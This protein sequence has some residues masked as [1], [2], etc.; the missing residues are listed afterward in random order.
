MPGHV[1][2]TC[3]TA[4]CDS[5]HVQVASLGYAQHALPTHSPPV[6]LCMLKRHARDMPGHVIP[7]MILAMNKAQGTCHYKSWVVCLNFSSLLKMVTSDSIDVFKTTA[8]ASI[9]CS[10]TRPQPPEC[11]KPCCKGYDKENFLFRPV[12]HGCSMVCCNFNDDVQS[13]YQTVCETANDASLSTSNDSKIITPRQQT[14][15][16]TPILYSSG[17][18]HGH[19]ASAD[20]SDL[21]YNWDSV[22]SQRPRYLPSEV[23]SCTL[24]KDW[25]ACGCRHDLWNTDESTNCKIVCYA[26]LYSASDSG[27]EGYF[28]DA[29]TMPL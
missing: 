1:I 28:S 12:L 14:L 27:D 16:D 29:R 20:F 18:C 5:G 26:P 19:K 7:P 25:F 3:P 6:I 13:T 24:C 11:N 10:D 9:A 22:L 17:N 8:K 23:K 15:Q 21:D 4:P 2:P